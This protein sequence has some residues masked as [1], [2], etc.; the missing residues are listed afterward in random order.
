MMK[1]MR[2]FSSIALLGVMAFAVSCD[3]ETNIGGGGSVPVAD[4]FYVAKVGSVPTASDG[5]LSEKVEDDGFA[6]QDREG[7]FSNY[8]FLTAGNYNVV[9]V[10]DQEISQTIGGT[11]APLTLDGSDCALNTFTLVDQYAVDGA[12]I[13]IATDG[14]YKVIMD[15]DTK[16][17]LFYRITK[18]HILGGATSFGFSQN[19]A[20]ELAQ[21]G[22]AT[23][24]GVTFKQNAIDLTSSDFKIRF[25]CRWTINRRTGSDFEFASGYQAFTNLGG[26]KEQLSAG[27]QNIPIAFG[28]DGKY[29]VEVKWTPADGFK[30]TMVNNVPIAPK[31]VNSYEWGVIGSATPG[32]WD[33]DTDLTLKSGSTATAATYEIASVALTAGGALKFRANNQWGIILKP[34]NSNV[35][36][37]NGASVGLIPTT[38]GDTQWDVA[39]TAGGNYKI[40]IATTNTGQT[41]AITFT[42]L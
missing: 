17:L 39:P 10:I 36:S 38:T 42:K 32:G 40:V 25:N 21:V 6:A 16:D 12:A 14:L 20:G 7:F 4:G 19:D 41:W 9:N 28:N 35:A 3:D 15:V 2:L 5:L 30:L 23:A 1:K 37:E 24:A 8:I 26:T 31:A 18:A 27:A 11:A 29:S 34:L 13:A 22:A 33:A